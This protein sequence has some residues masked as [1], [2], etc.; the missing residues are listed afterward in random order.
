MTALRMS[1]RLVQRIFTYCGK[2][3]RSSGLPKTAAIKT[4]EKVT[5]KKGGEL[6]L[7]AFLLLRIVETVANYAISA[8]GV[9]LT[10]MGW[11]PVFI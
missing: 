10:V 6:R 9:A 1:A 2:N 3:W 8:E 4:A 7:P 5:H 11:P